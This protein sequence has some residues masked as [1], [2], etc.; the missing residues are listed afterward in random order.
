MNA[1]NIM[2]SPVRTINN[3][4]VQINPKKQLTINS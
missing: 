2:Q 1:P 3:A 4:A